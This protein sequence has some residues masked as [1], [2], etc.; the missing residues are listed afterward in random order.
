VAIILSIAIANVIITPIPVKAY[1]PITK[2]WPMYRGSPTRTGEATDDPQGIMIP[3]LLWKQ[4]I[5]W[6]LSSPVIGNLD[7]DNY[8]DVVVCSWSGIH[9]FSGY[10]GS[11]LWTFGSA[12]NDKHSPTLVDL[13]G[14][15][16]MEVLVSSFTWEY[17]DSIYI[18]DNDG[19]LLDSFNVTD[20][21]E[22]QGWSL[23]IAKVFSSIAVA[24]IDNDSVL[25]AV[26]GVVCYGGDYDDF[27]PIGGTLIAISISNN[28]FST[29]D[30]DAYSTASVNASV[31]S[32]PALMDVDN[33]GIVDYV[34]FGTG[35]E[36]NS[37]TNQIIVVE[38]DNGNYLWSRSLGAPIKHTPAV[39]DINNDGTPE[40]I[41]N[42]DSTLY[43]LEYDCD[44]IDDYSAPFFDSDPA[45][46]DI[47]N[48][49]FTEIIIC[50][51]EDEKI[52]AFYYDWSTSSFEIKWTK[53]LTTD[54]LSCP[55]N[56]VWFSSPV[57]ADV[58]DDSIKDAVV[59]AA[60]DSTYFLCA[61]D[62]LTGAIL[63]RYEVKDSVYSSP[64]VADINND[65]TM[66][67][68]FSCNDYLY[69]ITNFALTS[70]YV[71]GVLVNITE[72]PPEKLNAI[73]VSDNVVLSF[74][75]VFSN[76]F[77]S[78]AVFGVSFDSL[79]W[80][81]NEFK[82][83]M[84]GVD[85]SNQ[86]KLD[87]SSDSIVFYVESLSPA[88]GSL[89]FTILFTA[90][91]SGEYTFNWNCTAVALPPPGPYTP[92]LDT[93]E[94]SSNIIV[95]QKT[96]PSEGPSEEHKPPGI[97]VEAVKYGAVCIV[98]IIIVLVIVTWKRR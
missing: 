4:N 3:K 56:S 67:M 27:Y 97:V 89:S 71:S 86:F 69:T 65:N 25:E 6:S 8:L 95:Q 16:L 85:V 77:G 18:I 83:Y 81:Y 74:K 50:E 62:G 41:V 58:N 34:I 20:Y 33:N 2:D 63:W 15:G 24:D 60:S 47:D 70:T 30:W 32:S 44:P 43:L 66:D 48:D 45:V 11:I 98:A 73:N 59:G 79:A 5:V 75:I 54:Y 31:Y 38:A 92:V 37:R 84:D 82:A 76:S 35:E 17:M 21:L 46:A 26:F 36:G 61:L 93:C 88:N 49:G 40:I 14:D 42:T 94:G 1:P 52:Y 87:I 53:D 80:S 7:G 68:A 12:H 13:D 78:S 91:E 72:V 39:K 29:V 55:D 64:A 19:T 51:Y 57:L 90:K 28:G 23:Y 96:A 10:D 22:S 9:A